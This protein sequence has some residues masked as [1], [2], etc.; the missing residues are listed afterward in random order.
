MNNSVS[1]EVNIP[2]GLAQGTCISSILYAL[3]IADMP[4]VNETEASLYA[5][6]TA[7]Y[8]S[9]KQTK[10]I[11]TRLNESLATLQHFFNRWKIK[12]NSAKTQAAIFPFDNKRRRR[13][14]VPLKNGTH[15]IE[16]SKSVKY[17]G[18]T[19]DSKLLF[20][21]LINNTIDKANKCFRALYSILAIGGTYY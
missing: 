11:I 13:P 8:T 2:A 5:D 15:I 7:V 18:I 4:V 3:Y 10:T 12:I 17:L 9:A 21:E 6:D 16:I 20:S 14:T 1:D 19:F